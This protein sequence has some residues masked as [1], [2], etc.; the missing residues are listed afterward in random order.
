[1]YP[2]IEYK[3]EDYLLTTDKSKIDLPAVHYYLSKESYWAQNIPLDILKTSIDNS[4]TFSIL[5]ENDQAGFARVVTDFSVFAY[6][7]DVYIAVQYRGKGL[8]KWLMKSIIETPE[9]QIIRRWML[10]THDAHGLYKK[11]GF[12]NLEH[13]ERAMEITKPAIYNTPPKPV[14]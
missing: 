7:A 13:P 1:M 5:K 11:Y 6:I 2:V 10:M 14:Q 4:I 8:S 3:K 12:K 9:L